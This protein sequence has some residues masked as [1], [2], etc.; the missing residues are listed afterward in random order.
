MVK[1]SMISNVAGT[2]RL[3][4]M[5]ATVSEALAMVLKTAIMALRWDGAGISL[6]MISSNTPNVPS[7]PTI[8]PLRL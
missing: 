6:S 1:L 2:M 8:S 5:A 4:I 7:E 3:A